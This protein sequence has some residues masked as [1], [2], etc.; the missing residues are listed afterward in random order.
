[1]ENLMRTIKAEEAEVAVSMTKLYNAVLQK[2]SDLLSA[3]QTLEIENVNTATAERQFA[4]GMLSKMELMQK[5]NARLSAEVNVRAA[6]LNLLQAVETY[7]WAKKGS[8]SLSQ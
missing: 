7:E 6:E 3:K 4:L 1:M 8:L 5:Q 2:E